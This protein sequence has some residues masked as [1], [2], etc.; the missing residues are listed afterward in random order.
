MTKSADQ[1]DELARVRRRDASV[2]LADRKRV[3]QF[4][5]PQRGDL[6]VFA[7]E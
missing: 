6:G 4:Q 5:V 7:L 3:G 2:A 1:G